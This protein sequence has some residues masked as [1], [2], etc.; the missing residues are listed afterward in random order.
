MSVYKIIYLLFIHKIFYGYISMMIR[1]QYHFA[2]F[3]YIQHSSCTPGNLIAYYLF[4][5]SQDKEGCFDKL[6]VA[7]EIMHEFDSGIII[8]HTLNSKMFMLE[9]SES[10]LSLA[11]RSC[12]RTGV[13]DDVG[14]QVIVRNKSN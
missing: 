13:K 6:V 2:A 9:T 3:E 1:K 8:D 7:K 12:P 4:K 14:F 10:L 11:L 5:N